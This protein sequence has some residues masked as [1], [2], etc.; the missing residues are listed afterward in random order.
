[1]PSSSLPFENVRSPETMFAHDFARF[2]PYYS[3]QER[4]FDFD[5]MSNASSV[6]GWEM[7]QLS[8]EAAV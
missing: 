3:R 5:N 8:S 4:S 2:S 1:M 6:T 7:L